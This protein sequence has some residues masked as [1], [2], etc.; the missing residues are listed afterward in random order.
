MIPRILEPEVMDSFEDAAEYDAMDH[1]AVNELFVADFLAALKDWSL[2]QPDAPGKFLNILDLGAGTAQ[3][4]ISLARRIPNVHITAVDAAASMLA[5]A[6][7]NIATAQLASSI[8]IVQADAKQLP[9]DSRAFHVVM[10]NSILHHIPEPKGVIAEAN[11]V[12]APAGLHFHRDLAR[13]GDEATLLRLVELYAA[14]ATPYQ[15]RLFTESLHAAL[16][17]EE[18]AELVTH[19][20]FDQKSVRK[21]S[22]RHWT[23]AVAK[24]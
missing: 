19:F 2:Q 14:A 1:S 7:L 18:M 3:I 12:T 8:S 9:F 21:T 20:G 17:A 23:W 5:L 11:R 15:R 13:P 22:D 16:T 10:S 6:E 24:S 4:P